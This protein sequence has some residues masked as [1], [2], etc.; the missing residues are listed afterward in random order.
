MAR[1]ALALALCIAQVLPAF[2]QD[3]ASAATPQAVQQSPILTLDQDRL[4]AETLWGKRSA[5]GI[6]AESQALQEENRKIEADLTAEERSLTD[7]RA[8]MDAAAFR[9]EAD[10]FDAKVVGIRAAQDAKQRDIASRREEDRQAF[11]SAALPVIGEVL[12]ARGAVIVIDKRSVFISANSV[13]ITDQ[14][15]ESLDATIGDGSAAAA[16]ATPDTTGNAP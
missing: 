4:F 13:D 2:A 9:A 14:L 7:R 3:E 11:L 10:A 6:E 15:I 1:A 8:T 16:P 5:A 12:K